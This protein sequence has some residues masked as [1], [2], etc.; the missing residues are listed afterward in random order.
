MKRIFLLATLVVGAL[1]AC[2]TSPEPKA[3]RTERD[4]VKKPPLAPLAYPSD[5][6]DAPPRTFSG[7]VLISGGRVMTA[8]GAVWEPGHVLIVDGKIA[9][10]G[11]GELTSVPEGTTVIDA[12]GHTVT[13]GIIDTHSHLGVYPQPFVDGNSDGNEMSAPNTAQVWA[14]HGFWPQDPGLWRALSGGITTIQVLPGSANLFG[15]RSFTAKL[16]PGVSARE[17]RFPDAPQGLKMACGE[18]PKR[19]Y[20][21]KGRAPTTRMGNVA[22]Y[23]EAFQRALEY[24]RRWEKHARDL[25]HWQTQVDAAGDDE[26]KRAKVGDPPEPPSRDFQLETLVGVL[27]GDILVH[28]HCY[29]ADEMHLMM[30][31]ANTYGF[32]IRS[33]HH[34]VEAYKLRDRL[35]AEGTA[36]STWADWWGFKMEAFDG[37]PQNAAL[38]ED[39]GARAIIHSDSESDIR[40]LNQE[41]QKARTAGKKIGI[42]VSADRALRWITANP[43]W[44]LGIDD[45]VGTLEPGKMADVVIWSGDVFS[46]YS[47]AEK[48]LIDGELVLDREQGLFPMGDFELGFREEALLDDGSLGKDEGKK[49]ATR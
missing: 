42:D 36:I 13:P 49:E 25:A 28:N 43:A 19:N 35:A 30:D 24:R 29:R 15:G 47:R 44:A 33:F 18:N 39:A 4:D 40:R 9:A 8:A 14:E 26:Q 41:A 46:V 22:G 31:L 34:A 2:A 6:A 16:R 10:V 11:P 37:I 27:D 48:V 45:K 32:K 23:R 7:T 20:G 12:A 1:A 5:P 17:M 38:L 21:M 3:D